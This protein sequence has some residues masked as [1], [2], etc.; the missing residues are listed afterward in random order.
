MKCPN[1]GNE[2]EEGKL[3]CSVCGTEIQYV[4]NYE[5]ELEDSMD[6]TMFHIIKNEII[7]NEESERFSQKHPALFYA[8]IIIFFCFIIASV[9]FGIKISQTH[10][11]DYQYNKAI[12]YA[13]DGDYGHAINSLEKAIALDE[14]NIDLII[15]EAEYY[16][17]YGFRDTAKS[18]LE[19]AIISG[20]DTLEIYELLIA[21][22]VE[23]EDNI[24]IVSLLN[25]CSNSLVYEKYKNYISTPPKFSSTP[26]TFLNKISLEILSSGKGSIYYTLDGTLQTQCRKIYKDA[27]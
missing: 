7:V 4:P 6:R 15:L 1:C 11:F 20:H 9:F 19:N 27:I 14:E 18:I 3:L 21:Y 8:I 2:I 25:N 23:E 17:L 12:S 24:A 22:Y 10:S 13:E 5:P 26:G 16:N